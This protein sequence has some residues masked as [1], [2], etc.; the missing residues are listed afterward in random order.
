[1]C[2]FTVPSPLSVF[3]LSCAVPGCALLCFTMLYYAVLC[4]TMLYC[5]V[6]DVRAMY[7]PCAL[8][9]A[10][11][12]A[13]ASDSLAPSVHTW[14]LPSTYGTHPSQLALHEGRATANSGAKTFVDRVCVNNIL[15][16]RVHST[17][18]CT[19]Q[20]HTLTHNTAWT[21]LPH[22]SSSC[23]SSRAVLQ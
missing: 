9:C 11:E 22:S 3:N 5:T 18:A 23:N 21:H 4:C 1:V 13:C 12:F 2:Q 10:Q 20:Q 14:A 6:T 15:Q 7:P 17:A 16:Q 8:T 19:E